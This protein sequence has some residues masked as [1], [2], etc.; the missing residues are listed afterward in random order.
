[1]EQLSPWSAITE[2]KDIQNKQR[3]G[4]T[5][6]NYRNPCAGSGTQHRQKERNELNDK[7]KMVLLVFFLKPFFFPSDF[8]F[9]VSGSSVK[10]TASSDI[11]GVFLLC[12]N[13]TAITHHHIVLT[14]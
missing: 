8:F 10:P 6:H 13:L 1:M 9:L 11:W 14:S 3:V 2:A 12:L 4:P 7:I 5:H